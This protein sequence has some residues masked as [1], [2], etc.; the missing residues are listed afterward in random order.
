MAGRFG[1]RRFTWSNPMYLPDP[2][3]DEEYEDVDR[4]KQRKTAKKR[5]AFNIKAMFASLVVLQILV[6][7]VTIVLLWKALDTSV[8]T[9]LSDSGANW[10]K[11]EPCDH[12]VC[13]E[14]VD[15]FYCVC[16]GGWEGEFCETDVNECKTVGCHPLATCNNTAGSYICECHEGYEGD[17]IEAC[18][19]KDECSE[20]DICGPYSISC[21][22]T[23]GSYNCSC[24]PGFFFSGTTCTDI[25]ECLEE[26]I[27]GPY[28]ISC[29]NTIGSYDCSCQQ[30]FFSNGTTCEDVEEC[31]D[32]DICGPHSICSNTIGSYN[33]SCTE[34]YRLSNGTECEDINECLT[35]PC[36]D[37]ADCTNLPGNYSCACKPSYR[38]DGKVSCKVFLCESQ[39]DGW[40]LG[41]DITDS[42]WSGG[43]QASLT[44]ECNQPDSFPFPTPVCPGITVRTAESAPNYTYCAQSKNCKWDANYHSIVTD[45]PEKMAGRYGLQRSTWS[46]PMYGRSSWDHHMP[47]EYEDV[48]LSWTVNRAKREKQRKMVKKR[49]TQSYNLKAILVSLIV[50]QILLLAVT[51]VILWKALDTSPVS[52]QPP[53][54]DTNFCKDGPC[55]NGVCVEAADGFYC[56]CRGG[57]EGEFCETDVDECKTVECHPLATCENTAGSYTCKCQEGYEG[58]GKE[59]CTDKDECLEDICGPNS[60]SCS[61][62]IGSYN[63]SCQQ[64]FFFDGTSCA[65]VDECL[66]SPCHDF[67]DCTNLPGNYSCACK[68]QYRGDGKVSCKVFLCGSQEDGWALGEDITDGG[69]AGGGLTNEC[70]QPD[71]FPF[72]TPRCPHPGN[73]ITTAGRTD[74]GYTATGDSFFASFWFKAANLSGDGSRIMVVAGDPAGTDRASNYLE[75]HSLPEGITVRT[76]ESAPN[77]TYCAQSGNCGW[78]ANY[79]SIVT[80]LDLQTWHHVEMTLTAKP[81]DYMDQWQYRVDGTHTFTGGAYY[82]TARYDRV[83][84]DYTYANRLKFQ[85][86]HDNWDAKFQGFF[87]DDIHYGVF[88]SGSPEN[89]IEEYC[90]SFEE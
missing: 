56:V 49:K 41:K 16:R 9:K 33:C 46:N 71:S 75:V 52:P 79:H 66:T 90:V 74:V 23:I 25:D 82:Q 37:F 47:E 43:A 50:L 53:D 32:E 5:K 22:N 17:G 84:W 29:S 11:D 1:L 30:G 51:A 83:D 77:Y 34:G 12:G 48:E 2:H 31:E 36:H 15:G 89:V 28:S 57:W 88:D 80:G 40:A 18:T 87:F 20:E 14:A 35:S 86:R 19:D 61:N 85:P 64:G 70:N 8:A 4:E 10:C 6:L 68:A 21:S 59:A 45:T 55:D 67:A 63:C 65:D 81:V 60:I 76:A 27:C 7:A 24:Q 42:G 54:C 78:N 38:G 26:D 13:L 44:N 3:M 39:E 69:W 72:P 62:T 73:A 58:D